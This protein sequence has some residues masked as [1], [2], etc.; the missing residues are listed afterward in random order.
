MNRFE[1][2]LK[3]IRFDDLE[4]RKE[5]KNDDKFAPFRAMWE[6]FIQN[7]KRNYNPS[8][9]V[10]IDEQLVPFRGR[11]CFRQYLPSKPDKYGLKIFLL[12]DCKTGYIYHGIPYTGGV[13]GNGPTVGLASKTVK[14][15]VSDLHDS[16][17][18]ITADNFFTDF[19]LADELL[20]KRLT[21]VGTVRKNKKDLPPEFQ[22]DKNRT[23]GSS[24]FGFDKNVTIVSYVPKRNKSVTLLSTMH[25]DNSVDA[26]SG[27]PEIILFYNATKGAV[28]TV[29]QLCHSYSVQRKTK[30]WPLACFYN[31]LNLTCINA[32]VI[33]MNSFPNW[34]RSKLNRRRLFLLELGMSLVKPT[35]TMRARCSVGIQRPIQEAIKA[36][37]TQESRVDQSEGNPV[38]TNVNK[39]SRK[40]CYM[41]LK[42]DRKAQRICERCKNPVC[43]EHSSKRQSITCLRKCK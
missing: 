37:Q 2:I 42:K 31:L 41:C 6:M 15:L 20:L 43:G 40:R 24:L 1:I 16:G 39:A 13:P 10:C 22:A 34:N 3:H 29:D 28:D 8:E 36:C 17:R 9:N 11:C 33:F 19:N 38:C 14:E 23:V 21:L 26:D 12:V 27:K 7:C 35:I 18:N 30:R 32:F 4:T 25:H 5:R